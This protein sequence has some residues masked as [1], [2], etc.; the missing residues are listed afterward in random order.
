MAI[1]DES[2]KE[3]VHMQLQESGHTDYERKAWYQTDKA[4]VVLLWTSSKNNNRLN[5]RQFSVDAQTYF[6]V[7]QECLRGLEGMHIQQKS[8]GERKNMIMT[9]DPY[10]ENT[11]K[12]ILP[13]SGWT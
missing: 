8:G 12:A 2:K 4:N 5:T 10:G 7:R 11:A 1:C 13:G 3:W 6:G 9:C